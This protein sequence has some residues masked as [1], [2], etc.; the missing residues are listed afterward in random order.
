MVVCGGFGGVA[1]GLT[2]GK[3]LVLGGA[4]DDRY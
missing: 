3:L 4:V 2:I 1:F